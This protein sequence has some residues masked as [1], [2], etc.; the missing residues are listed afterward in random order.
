MNNRFFFVVEDDE[1]LRTSLKGVLEGHGYSVLEF[2]SAEEFLAHCHANIDQ[3]HPFSRQTSDEHISYCILMDV[4]LAG[5]T[6]IDAQVKFRKDFPHIPMIFMSGECNAQAVNQ[7]WRDGAHDFIFK[8]FQIAEL[9]KLIDR[10][11]RHYLSILATES[12]HINSIDVPNNAI[13]TYQQTSLTK[14]EL[15]V[16][17]YISEG[18]KNQVIADLLGISLRTVKMHRSN[19][20][21]KLKC[22]HV[23]DLVRFYE[24]SRSQLFQS[25]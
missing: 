3:F 6:G 2:S 14:R 9:L 15:Q 8:P 18:N 23:A 11:C 21:R 13:E 20:M 10:A 12:V 1:S 25:G 24:R 4:G 22:A 17:Q 19:L 16:L 7:A 5:M